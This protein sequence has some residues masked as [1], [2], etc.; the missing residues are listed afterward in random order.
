MSAETNQDNIVVSLEQGLINKVKAEMKARNV[1]Q[2]LVAKKIG[3]S[4]AA[5]SQWLRGVYKGSKPALEDKIRRWLATGSEVGDE[6]L[7][8]PDYVPTKT[9][10]RICST[11]AFAQSAHEF[12]IVY[13]GAGMGKTRSAAHY[14][15]RHS[16]AW[17][18]T[19]TPATSSMLSVLDKI[20]A[21]VGVKPSSRRC[22]VLEAEILERIKHTD[23]LLIIDEAQH[24]HVKVLEQVRAIFDAS[25]IGLALLGNDT[26]YSR[27]TGGIRTASF[28]QLFSRVSKR[29]HLRH[30]LGGDVSALAKALGIE[31]AAEVGQLER[32][33]SR[34]GAL[35]AVVYTARLA[36]LIAAGEPI[37]T[38]HLRDAWRDL[39]EQTIS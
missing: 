29:V 33:A 10:K 19:I 31:G 27:L 2:T 11:L 14:A 24:L 39:T 17:L 35:R 20:A 5:L 13:G 28:A 1:S 38:D 21:A 16:N 30:P 9:G 34:H 32:I 6:I 8:I 4:S 36:A 15:L 22:A 23:G 37:S 7:P 12:V 18:T 26:I 3:T 25:D